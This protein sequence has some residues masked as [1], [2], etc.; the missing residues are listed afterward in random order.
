MARSRGA[1]RADHGPTSTS[2]RGVGSRWSVLRCGFSSDQGGRWNSS[3]MLSG[4][5]K[6]SATPAAVR[7]VLGPSDLGAQAAEPLREFL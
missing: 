7:V 5:R 2:A 3:W 4:S 1:D 6:V